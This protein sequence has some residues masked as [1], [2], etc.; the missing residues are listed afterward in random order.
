MDILVDFE[1]VLERCNYWE[2]ILYVLL[3]G[4]ILY[5]LYVGE[6]KMLCGVVNFFFDF[7]CLFELILYRMM[8]MLY[9]VNEEGGGL[10]F[11]VVFVVCEVFNKLDNE[12]FG[13]LSM[14]MLFLG[15]Y[16]DF[17]VVEVMLCCDW[18][19]VDLIVVEYL[20]LLY[21]VVLFLDISCM[22]FLIRLILN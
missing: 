5:V 14:V 16:C 1:G 13:V 20:V 22:K 18:C 3:V 19:I 6:D 2:K 17:M 4:V 15:L 9:F 8:I 21:F 11:V 7:V 12:C 10:Y